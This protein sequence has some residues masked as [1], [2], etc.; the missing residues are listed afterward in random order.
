[1]TL[2]AKPPALDAMPAISASFLTVKMGVF[3]MTGCA[4][5][6]S[7][8]RSSNVCLW[9]IA[10]FGGTAKNGRYRCKADIKKASPEDSD[11]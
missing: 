5:P 8:A 10:T 2:A 1:M 11:S 3:P 9:H 6:R 7:L 4:L